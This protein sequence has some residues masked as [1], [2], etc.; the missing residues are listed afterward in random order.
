MAIVVAPFKLES[1]SLVNK[2][3]PF[4]L[5]RKLLINTSR[6]AY[7]SFDYSSSLVN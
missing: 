6:F 2:P 4:A 7:D 3:Y 1:L 5:C